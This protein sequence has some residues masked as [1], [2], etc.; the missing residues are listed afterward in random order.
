MRDNGRGFDPARATVETE[1]VLGGVHL[2]MTGMS[3]RLQ[4]VGGHLD[5]ESTP[6]VGTVIRAT[7]PCPPTAVGPLRAIGAAL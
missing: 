7:V 1:D 6:G 4:I 2:G 3:E 5:V